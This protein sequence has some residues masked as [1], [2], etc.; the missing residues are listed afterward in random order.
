MGK[1]KKSSLKKK[2][3]HGGRREGAGRPRKPIEQP[4]NPLNLG[5]VEID[6]VAKPDKAQG[7]RD[8]ARFFAL[9]LGLAGGRWRP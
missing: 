9:M 6:L 4:F 3:G 8:A 7:K 1:A 5:A 2:S